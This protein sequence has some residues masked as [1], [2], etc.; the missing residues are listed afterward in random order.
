[1]IVDRYRGQS[2][3]YYENALRFLEEGETE[4]AAE[5]LWGSVAEALKAVAATRGIVLR[6]HRDVREYARELA[7]ELNDRSIFDGFKEANSLHADFYEA[8]LTLDDV[9]D[10]WDQSIRPTLETLNELLA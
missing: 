2:I 4:K 1:M 3:H 7:K 8:G 9:K 6:S 10:A 5:F